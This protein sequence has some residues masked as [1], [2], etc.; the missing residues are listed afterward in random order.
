MD[1]ALLVWLV[2]YLYHNVCCGLPD[3]TQLGPP[4]PPPPP[5]GEATEEAETLHRLCPTYASDVNSPLR[6]VR[7]RIYFTSE[8]HIHSLVNVLRYCNMA[9]AWGVARP[10]LSRTTS[11]MPSG[12]ADEAVLPRGYSSMPTMNPQGTGFMRH[13]VSEPRLNPNSGPLPGLDHHGPFASQHL[14]PLPAV[15]ERPG[16]GT[17]DLWPADGSKAGPAGATA[18][19]AA[20]AAAGGA[21][22]PMS[23]AD[24]IARRRSSSTSEMGACQCAV[25]CCSQLSYCRP[26]AMLQGHLAAARSVA[27]SCTCRAC[28]RPG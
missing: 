3:L 20:A 2:H 10:G 19:G 27:L 12:R 16:A 21:G 26:G 24:F 8:S 11:T 25:M 17:P 13:A 5:S 18:A 4:P 6:H 1:A 7:T 22:V 28:H 23:E 15:P 14:G 9:Q